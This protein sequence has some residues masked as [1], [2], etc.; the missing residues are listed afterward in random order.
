[1]ARSRSTQDA[2]PS[3]AWRSR[4]ND[5]ELMRL[6]LNV[7]YTYDVEGRVLLTN[8]PIESARLPGPDLSLA[9]SDG[10][11]IIRGGA[12]L[13]QELVDRLGAIRA[14]QLLPSGTAAY[15]EA[16]ERELIPFGKWSRQGGPAYR[17]PRVPDFSEHPVEITQQTRSVLIGKKQWLYDEYNLWGTAFMVIRDGIAVAT[18]FSSRI[19]D[20]SAEAGVWT[21]PGYRGQGLAGFVTQSWAA[22]VFA[23]GRIPF[24]STS[25]DNTASQA[26]A[27]K[28]GLVQI[29]EDYSWS[30]TD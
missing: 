16:I 7:L 22:A 28:L 14:D 6:R 9:I 15:I 1:M 30:R 21:D 5:L 26:V 3:S 11:S 25:F 17:F 27:R 8:E 29:G 10:Q 18:C 13:P 23:S 20:R 19:D 12:G 24:Y 4:L 2:R